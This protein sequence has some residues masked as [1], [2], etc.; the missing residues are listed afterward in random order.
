MTSSPAV[1][2]RRRAPG[3]A[4]RWLRFALYAVLL[5]AGLAL[6]ADAIKL[7]LRVLASPLYWAPAVPCLACAV[8]VL[9]IGAV[10]ALWL[11]G[12]TL[13]GWRM[14]LWSHLIPIGL[15]AFTIFGGPLGRRPDP[16]VGQAAPERALKAMAALHA[17]IRGPAEPCAQGAAA[18]EKALA[19][20]DVPPPGFRRFGVG[21]GWRVVAAPG[22]GPV[23]VP[24]PDDVPGTLYLVCDAQAGRYWISA[25]VTDALP[26]GAP[27]MARDG[28]GRAAVITGEVR[29]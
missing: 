9:A 15:L 14:P 3:P 26:V 10:Y 19:R 29:R 5:G 21:G 17:A 2:G 12:G 23:K 18:L 22:R 6:N 27:T 4:L 20:P 13:A 1:A 7:S 16:F 25:L 11:A 24:R 28:V 8:A